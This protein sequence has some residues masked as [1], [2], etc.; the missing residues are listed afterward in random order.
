M[1]EPAD[2]LVDGEVAG[3]VTASAPRYRPRTGG[4]GAP[5][6]SR[7]ALVKIRYDATTPLSYRAADWLVVD[8]DGGRH[9]AAAAQPN[10]ALGEGDLEA[11]AAAEASLAF[12]VPADVNVSAIVLR[13]PGGG[14][15]LLAFRVP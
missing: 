11:G 6:G 9:P 12:E 3:T 1:E 14:R 8:A 5:E 7:F 2:V 13:A 10:E 15:D 4:E